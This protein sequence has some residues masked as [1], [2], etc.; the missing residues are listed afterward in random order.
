[1]SERYENEA[2]MERERYSVKCATGHHFRIYNC[3]M[4]SC[5]AYLLL[6]LLEPLKVKHKI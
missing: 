5:E 6:F 3:Q 4:G 1:M 2:E